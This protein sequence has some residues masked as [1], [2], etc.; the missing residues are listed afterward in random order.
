SRPAA[1]PSLQEGG[2]GSVGAH[3]LGAAWVARQL[4]RG[5]RESRAAR[6]RVAMREAAPRW[7]LANA[8]ARRERSPRVDADEGE[9]SATAALTPAVMSATRVA[10]P[11]ARASS[12]ASLKL[13]VCGPM[14]TGQPHAA[15][16]IRFWPPSGAKL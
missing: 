1:L 14:T 10:A 9:A 7:A 12:A 15:A 4:G 6:M 13:K 8:R 3:F 11:A 16:S 2:A 5:A